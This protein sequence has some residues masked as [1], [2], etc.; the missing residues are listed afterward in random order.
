MRKEHTARATLIALFIRSHPGG[1]FKCDTIRCG[2]TII[3]AV[4]CTNLTREFRLS[5]SNN[6]S[7]SQVVLMFN[8]VLDRVARVRVVL[9][10]LQTVTRIL[11]HARANT[12]HFE[13]IYQC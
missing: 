13:Q 1:V 2:I 6:L 7:G 8:R 5:K 11:E 3:I 12:T 9:F 4:L 10:S